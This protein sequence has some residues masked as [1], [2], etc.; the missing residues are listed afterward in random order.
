MGLEKKLD[1]LNVIP[2]SRSLRIAA[3][4]RQVRQVSKLEWMSLAN[5][6]RRKC[7]DILRLK[8]RFHSTLGELLL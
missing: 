1:L 7:Q 5:G 8:V 3:V 2:I 6:L 4:V